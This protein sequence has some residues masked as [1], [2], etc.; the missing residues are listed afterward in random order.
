MAT[1]I[2]VVFVISPTFREIVGLTNIEMS[3]HEVNNDINPGRLRYT[4]A[5]HRVLSVGSLARCCSTRAKTLDR[6]M[7]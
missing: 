3:G 4:E 6:I 7:I 2:Q 1:F 5:S